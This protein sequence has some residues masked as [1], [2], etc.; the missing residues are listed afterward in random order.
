MAKRISKSRQV[1][2]EILSVIDTDGVTFRNAYQFVG[3][4]CKARGIK[5]DDI[6][7]FVDGG[8]HH[9]TGNPKQFRA[10]TIAGVTVKEND[11]GISLRSLA[12]R[13]WGVTN[14]WVDG[15]HA[16]SNHDT[17]QEAKD[18][19][20]KFIGHLEYP[21]GVDGWGSD[22]GDHLH[23]VRLNPGQTVEQYVD[24]LGGQFADSM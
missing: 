16:I 8:A 6:V 2:Q 23:I 19:V 21:Q 7:T 10:F 13:R 20:K 15:F 1:A 14:R 4:Y 3:I 22:D 24:D 18:A 5:I 12:K 17:Y 9:R 11:L